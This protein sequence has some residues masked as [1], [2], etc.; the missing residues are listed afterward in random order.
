MTKP[1]ADLLTTIV[2]ATRRIVEVRRSREPLGPLIRRAEARTDRL[3][4]TFRAALQPTDRVNVIAECKRRSPSRGV[5]RQQYDAAA[6]A[7]VYEEAGAAAISVLT[8]STFFDGSLEH[9]RAVTSRVTIPVLRKDF[10]VDEYQIAE[11][12]AEGADA[13]LLIAAA[14][15]DSALRDL[16]AAATGL[17]LDALIEI[18][19]ASELDRALAVGADL[20]GVNNRNL[21]TLA[22]DARVSADL[23]DRIPR[24]VTAVAE[25]GFTSSSELAAL[26]DAGYRAFLVGERLMTSADPGRTLRELLR[27]DSP[28][29][30]PVQELR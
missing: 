28:S 8:E 24:D 13:V 3:A 11:A 1:D 9:L 29:H 4:G 16:Q 12:A 22:V 25:S 23:I 5:F 18:H 10:V 14:L 19:D 21:R 7:A 26:R 15:A 20:I 2:A 17:G 6:I 27:Q 30:N